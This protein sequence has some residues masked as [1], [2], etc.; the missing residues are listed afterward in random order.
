MRSKSRAR[1]NFPKHA[2]LKKYRV[3]LERLV[4]K[5]WNSFK[6]KQREANDT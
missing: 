4:L 5:N 3:D 2:L 1:V 6:A